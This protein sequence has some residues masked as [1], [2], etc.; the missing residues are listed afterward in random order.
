[1]KKL[2]I[3]SLLMLSSISYSRGVAHV[4]R[5]HSVSRPRVSSARSYS[6][7]KVVSVRPVTKTI[8]HK[9][10]IRP[11]SSSLSSIGTTAKSTAKNSS[12]TPILHKKSAFSSD[13]S[14][15][16]SYSS[17]S[18][19]F[20][21]QNNNSGLGTY[22]FLL[23]NSI[24]G[25]AHNSKVIVKDEHENEFDEKEIILILEKEIQ[26][27]KSKFEPNKKKIEKYE[28]LIKKLKE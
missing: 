22:D 9:A 28:E 8:T 5:V 7:P 1:M 24:L 26:E 17:G 25:R 3:V 6:R 15:N 4:S 12:F 13:Y 23:L 18:S 21:H 19:S 11:A 2:L 20:Y 10:A 27:E 14:S 16:S